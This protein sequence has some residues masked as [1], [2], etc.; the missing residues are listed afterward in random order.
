MG[1]SNWLM[2]WIADHVC[3]NNHLDIICTNIIFLL[4]GYDK[5]QM[6]ETM[7][8]TIASHTPSGTST[9]TVRSMHR[10]SNISGLEVWTGGARRRIKLIMELIILHC[11]TCIKSIL[12]LL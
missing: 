4:T 3:G 12:R 1:P 10:R 7:V 2:D 11:T 6:N 9:Y 5:P 8:P